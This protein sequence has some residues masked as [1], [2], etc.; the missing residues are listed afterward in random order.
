ML[1]VDCKWSNLQWSGQQRHS[2]DI[3][4]QKH[5]KLL[6]CYFVLGI[7]VQLDDT[8]GDKHAA[9]LSNLITQLTVKHPDILSRPGQKTAGGIASANLIQLK[10]YVTTNPSRKSLNWIQTSNCRIGSYHGDDELPPPF[11]PPSMIST[12]FAATSTC[13]LYTAIYRHGSDTHAGISFSF[14]HFFFLRL[15]WCPDGIRATQSHSYLDLTMSLA[16]RCS[17]GLAWQ[18][19]NSRVPVSPSLHHFT[20]ET[21]IRQEHFTGFSCL[22]LEPFSRAAA[23]GYFHSAWVIWHAG[24]GTGAL[25]PAAFPTQ[26]L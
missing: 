14:L 4:D 19:R 9:P 13:V 5:S 24:S 26:L 3:Q 23:E 21:R 17:S 7:E 22:F 1:Q 18:P 12:L 16:V 11:F 15:A 2:S 8:S 20:S 25:R 6:H 10:R